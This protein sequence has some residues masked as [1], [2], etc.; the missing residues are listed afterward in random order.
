MSN[1]QAWPL[2]LNLHIFLV[3]SLPSPRCH[4]WPSSGDWNPNLLR[5]LHVGDD[6]LGHPNGLVPTMR[7]LH[8]P[9]LACDHLAICLLLDDIGVALDLVLAVGLGVDEGALDDGI[10]P[11]SFA[12][13]HLLELRT[14]VELVPFFMTLVASHGFTLL[15]LLHHVITVILRRLDLSLG[16][17]GA[18][19]LQ[20]RQMP[21]EPFNF[22]LELI[23]FLCN[24]IITS[25]YNKILMAFLIAKG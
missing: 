19:A 6:F 5:P 13:S 1:L 15:K 8:L 20:V 24:E 17:H 7:R 25:F 18:L 16:A 11:L 14:L 12:L 3:P 9:N 2:G 21:H 23:I 22:L 4:S 10:H